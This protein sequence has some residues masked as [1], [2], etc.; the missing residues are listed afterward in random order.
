MMGVTNPSRLYR[1][2]AGLLAVALMA[3]AV[4]ATLNAQTTLQ[5]PRLVVR[6]VTTGDLTLYKLPSTTQVSGGLNTV[7][8]G[9]PWYLEVDVDA[10]IP[11]NNIAGVIWSIVT[12]PAGSNAALVASP[13]G[14]NVPVYEPSDRLIYQVA[15][16][17]LLIP[18]VHGVYIVSAT[19]TAGSSGT[20][21]VAQTFIAGTYTGISTCKECHNTG[22]AT[23][24][25]GPWS[26]TLHATIFTNGINGG[27]GTTGTSCLACHTV[28]YDANSTVNDGGFSYVAKQLGWTFP[29]TLQPGNWN[30]VPATL[31]NLANIQC[32][33][34]HGP[35]SEHAA[36]GGDALAISVPSNTGACNACHDAPARHI[37]GTSWENSV[38]AV[39][40]TDPAGNATCVGC[41][42]GTGFIQR[43]AGISPITDTSY[44]SIDCATCHE[45]HGITQ[46]ANGSGDTHQI[47]NMASVTLADG[48][49]I[50][51][52]GDD[53]Q[54]YPVSAG[55][56]LLCMQ[57]HQAR[58]NAA[59]YVPSTAGSVHY[60]PH[61]GPQADMLMGTNGFTYGESIP[62]SAHQFVVPNTCVT[63]HMQTVASTDP[64]FEHAGAHS[65][66]PS[67]TPTGGKKEDLVAA[68]QTCHGPDITT[69]DF[70]LF[71]YN[72]DGQVQGVQTEVQSMLDQLSTMLPPNNSVKTALT[73]D[74][75]WTKPQL[76]AAY[77]WTFVNNDGSKG[78]HNTAYAV[79]L[80]KAS[81]AN[82]QAGK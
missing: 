59:T 43:M 61:E 13:L 38:H 9:E 1:A 74:S 78:I 30:A 60:G 53:S 57:C 3:V 46:P 8:L 48:T 79:G 77:N 67:Y 70:P 36:N 21:T 50:P 49:K 80:L 18:D 35:G 54:G 20:T 71:D 62:T 69:F 24:M 76:E 16:R 55:E 26:N 22:P 63:C 25:V 2:L 68:C 82:L 51:L 66:E 44:H 56:G 14:S 31:Q 29:T 19:V 47:R 10:T 34:C 7:G 72:G 33:N 75:T 41:H 6:A 15:G 4:P 32:E 39:T 11:A 27:S 37:T 58:Q 52:T 17:Q 45:P 40:T 28:G 73:I 81:I 12:K 65:F 5:A 23:Q 42:T 64:A